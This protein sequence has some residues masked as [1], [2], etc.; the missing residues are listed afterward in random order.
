MDLQMITVR[1]NHC[2]ITAV[3]YSQCIITAAQ[4][5]QCTVAAVQYSLCTATANVGYG[6]LTC[7]HVLRCALLFGEFRLLWEG[8]VAQGLGPQEVRCG[9]PVSLGIYCPLWMI[10]KPGGRSH[11]TDT[12]KQAARLCKDCWPILCGTCSICFVA[13]GAAIAWQLRWKHRNQVH[14]TLQVFGSP[15]NLCAEIVVMTACMLGVP[16]L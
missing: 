15:F 14:L 3:R 12:P 16:V 7:T 6:M 4:S 1:C 13:D 9:A 11:N 8:G 2:T 5:R 10:L